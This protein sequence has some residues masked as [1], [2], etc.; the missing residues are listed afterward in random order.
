MTPLVYT[1]PPFLLLVPPPILFLL[2]REFFKAES[3]CGSSPLLDAYVVSPTYMRALGARRLRPLYLPPL[4]PARFRPAS[5]PFFKRIPGA[6]CS[7]FPVEIF[8]LIEG[9]VGFL[10]LRSVFDKRHRW[11]DRF[12]VRFFSS[13]LPDP[14]V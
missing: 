7:L 6:E 12:E 13:S 2:V 10:L 11:A 3:D 8:L 4:N 9:F 5:P 14:F 1:K